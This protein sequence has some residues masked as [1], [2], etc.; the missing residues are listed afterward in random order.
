MFFRLWG[1]SS[2]FWMD[3]ENGLLIGPVVKCTANVGCAKESM[4]S[5]AAAPWM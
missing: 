1:F 5:L 4:D 3:F 2:G